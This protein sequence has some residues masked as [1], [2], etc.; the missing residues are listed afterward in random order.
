MY[1]TLSCQPRQ[2]VRAGRPL[3]PFDDPFFRSFF[4][5]SDTPRTLGMRVDIHDNGDNF[6]LEAELP[7]M[8]EEQISLTVEDNVL[9]ISAKAEEQKKD[10]KGHYYERR[11]DSRQRSFSLEGIEQEGIAASYK[12][13][14][15][16]VTLPKA[17]PEPKPAQRNI[18]IVKQAE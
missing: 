17:Q 9:T 6:S 13:G 2:A 5:L 1:T 18:P 10:E 12:N 16:Y 3:F 7:G 14:I 15:L 4:D 8:A 11:Y